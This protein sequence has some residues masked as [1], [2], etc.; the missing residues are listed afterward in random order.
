MCKIR[1]VVNQEYICSC[2][3]SGETKDCLIIKIRCFCFYNCTNIFN[4]LIRI[5][6]TC[7]LQAAIPSSF[8][9]LAMTFIK[10]RP[11]IVDN[12]NILKCQFYFKIKFIYD[13]TKL[14]SYVL[15]PLY[16]HVSIC[17]RTH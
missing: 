8:K 17:C 11:L 2:D 9:S 15:F 5:Y 3:R 13:F 10:L 16:Q 12:K 14:M 4:I 1:L 7:I 6:E